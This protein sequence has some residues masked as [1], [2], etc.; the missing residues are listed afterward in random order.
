MTEN[1]YYGG[2]LVG[3]GAFN[4]SDRRLKSDIQ[5]YDSGM[6]VV[7]AMNTVSFRYL[8][9]ASA[10]THYGVIAQELQQI[11]P[12][13][14]NS[15]VNPETGGDFLAVNVPSVVFLMADALQE[16]DAK[17]AE[18]EARLDAMEAMLQQVL[19]INLP[20]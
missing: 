17:N 1:L 15:F 10:T 19:G 14:V 4:T 2:V 7:R 13:L 11:D 6:D 3:N 20:K 9:D 8:N 5:A 12:A 18:L 16:A